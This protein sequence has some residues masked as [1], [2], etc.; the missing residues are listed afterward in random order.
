VP[1]FYKFI[2]SIR[3]FREYAAAEGIEMRS[4]LDFIWMLASALMHHLLRTGFKKVVKQPLTNIVLRSAAKA[5]KTPPNTVKTLRQTTDFTTYLFMVLV[6]IYSVFNDPRLPTELGG[7]GTV[8]SPGL[9]WPFLSEGGNEIAHTFWPQGLRLY[10]IIISGYQI[11]STIYHLVTMRDHNNFVDMMLHHFCTMMGVSY[12]Y[13]TNNEDFVIGATLITSISDVCLN[14]GKT[15]RDI[16]FH[17]IFVSGSYLLILFSWIITR[18]Y[19]FTYA[20]AASTYK[21]WPS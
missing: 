16:G 4:S 5:G 12:C 19:F 17:K 21:F 2:Q 14:F 13:F 11:R 7:A 6:G 9:Y 3:H 8:Y 1:V 10:C 20:C 15:V 18:V